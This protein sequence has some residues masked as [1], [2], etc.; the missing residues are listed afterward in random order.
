MRLKQATDKGAKPFQV[1]KDG[2]LIGNWTIQ[3]QC[4]RDLG[5]GQREI[6]KCLKGERDNINAYTFKII[7]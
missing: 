3:R 5:L 2:E 4:S 6:G 7:G 1:F